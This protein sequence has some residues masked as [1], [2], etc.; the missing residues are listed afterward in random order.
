MQIMATLHRAYQQ[1]IKKKSKILSN[2]SHLGNILIQFLSFSSV[3]YLLNRSNS[4]TSGPSNKPTVSP[5]QVAILVPLEHDCLICSEALTGLSEIWHSW[6]QKGSSSIQLF[7]K[8]LGQKY[9]KKAASDEPSSERCF[10]CRNRV[11]ES[12]P[13]EGSSMTTSAF[14]RAALHAAASRDQVSL[15]AAGNTLF[16]SNRKVRIIIEFLFKSRNRQRFLV[17][18]CI[19]SKTGTAVIRD[20]AFLM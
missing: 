20:E 10:F 5:Q 15:R 16:A 12:T 11:V 6:M 3:I 14:A 8:P 4:S 7:T 1:R 17:I 18:S 9:E 19:A 13:L 2:F